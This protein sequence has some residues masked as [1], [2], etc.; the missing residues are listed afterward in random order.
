MLLHVPPFTSL[1]KKL[2]IMCSNKASGTTEKKKEMASLGRWKGHKQKKTVC[3]GK[4]FMINTLS[5]VQI[6]NS[7]HRNNI[8]IF[9]ISKVHC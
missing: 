4:L 8:L 2:H 5:C 7:H 3:A 6:Q 1:F 9:K